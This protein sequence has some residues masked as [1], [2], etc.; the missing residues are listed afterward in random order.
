MITVTGTWLSENIK[1]VSLVFL[2]CSWSVNPP[3]SA[4][5]HCT[6]L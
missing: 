1:S 6:D 3:R 5:V 4:S 2:C